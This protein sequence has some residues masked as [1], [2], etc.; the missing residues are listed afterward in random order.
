[1]DENG[2]KYWLDK[3]GS[4][5]LI[6]RGLWIVC[7]LLLA[8]DF[9]YEKHVVFAFEEFPAFYGIF[10]FVGIF[11]IVLAGKYLRKLIGRKEDYYD[12]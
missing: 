3:P 12:H 9:L 1:M 10:G 6:Y 5:R 8:A 2:K 4:V 7:A 11:G